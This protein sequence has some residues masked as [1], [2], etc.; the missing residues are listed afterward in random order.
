[1]ISIDLLKKSEMDKI[2]SQN[3][4]FLADFLLKNSIDSFRG[5]GTLSRWMFVGKYGEL[6]RDAV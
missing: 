2:F 4:I 5:T 1:M 3:N 6:G